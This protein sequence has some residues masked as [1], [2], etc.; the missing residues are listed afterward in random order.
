MA[1]TSTR[2]VERAL[3]LLGAVCERGTLTLAEAARD[4]GLSASTAL[5]L[6]RTLES[7]GFVRRDDAGGYRPGLRV[8]QLGAQALSSESLVSLAEGSLD[9]LVRLTGESAYLSVPSHDAHGIYLAV[10]EGTH[11]VRH[12]SWVGRSIPLKGT[13]VGAVLSGATPPAGFV[14]VRDGVEADVTAI[15]A[16][17]HA[18]GRIAAALSVVVPSYRISED[19]AAGIGKQ[20][21]REAAAILPGTA[22]TTEGETA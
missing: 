11:S 18:G 12:A 10:R 8:V 6:L 13:A 1:D 20:V 15:A 22:R 7:T 2:T 19:E 9:R 4:A 5:R 21:A 14:V 17:V 16:P 3:Q